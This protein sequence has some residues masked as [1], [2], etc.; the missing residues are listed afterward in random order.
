MKNFRYLFLII[1]IVSVVRC[2]GGKADKS[3]TKNVL[4]ENKIS[5]D[6]LLTLVEYRT[7]SISGMEPNLTSGMA[8]ERFHVDG[9]L[10]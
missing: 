7:F 4:S 2:S 9:S 6:S 3:T 8:R 1:I 10:S 5:D